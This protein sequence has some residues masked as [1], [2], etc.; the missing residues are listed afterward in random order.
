MK[1]IKIK[2]TIILAVL[3]LFNVSAFSQFWPV[4][5]QTPTTSDRLDIRIVSLTYE[6]TCDATMDSICF[7]LQMKVG[8]GY[9]G[10]RRLGAMN[11][12]IDLFLEPG[13]AI[14]VDQFYGGFVKFSPPWGLAGGMGGAFPPAPWGWENSVE[15]KASR[16]NFNLSTPDYQTIARITIPISSTT[17]PTQ[18]SYIQ[19]RVFNVDLGSYWTSPDSY[20]DYFAFTPSADRYYFG[21]CLQPEIAMAD[22]TDKCKGETVNLIDYA[23]VPDM[24]TPGDVDVTFWK[25][26]MATTPPSLGTQIVGSYTIGDDEMLFA[27]ASFDGCDSIVSFMVIT[28]SPLPPTVSSPQEFCASATVGDLNADGANVLWYGAPTGGTPLLPTI[29]LANNAVYYATQTSD[30][31][32]ESSRNPVMVLIVPETLLPS[33]VIADQTLCTDATVADIQTDGSSGIVFFNPSGTELISTDG[34]VNGTYTAIYRYGSGLNVCESTNPT[35]FTITLDNNPALAPSIADQSFCVGATIA[36][37]TVPNNQIVWYFDDNPAST[38]LTPG[39]KLVDNTYYASQGKGGS[40]AEST[41]VPVVITIGVAEPPT[42]HGPYEF[43]EGATLANI[44]L[45]GYGTMLWYDSPGSSTPLAVT[46]ELPLGTSIYY[47]EQHFGL[48]SSAR[49]AVPVTVERCN[50]LLECDSMPNRIVEERAFGDRMYTVLDASWDIS[51]DIMATL[52]SARYIVDGTVVSSGPTATLNGTIFPLGV[53][54]VMVIGF[55][56]S[57]ADTCE[58][59]VTVE[60]LCPATTS[61]AVEPHVYTVTKLAGTCW[62][63]NLRATV[64]GDNTSIAWAKLYTSSIYSD[65]AHHDSVFGRLYTWYSAVGQAEPTRSGLV[66]GPCPDGWHVPSQAEWNLLTAYD[67][68]DLKSADPLHWLT[69][70][71]DAYGFDSR[72]AGR[73]DSATGRFVDLYGFTGYWAS[74]TLPGQNSYAFMINYYCSEPEIITILG[75]DG[76]SVRCVI[77]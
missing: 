72:P 42:T 31:G 43:C 40:C 21:E 15:L 56:D 3:L 36:N 17:K 64:Y 68:H 58:F 18:D 30:D 8:S 10:A 1:S 35:T 46:T 11:L 2:K 5:E 33:P 16:S 13:V 19:F 37:I 57:Y 6:L 65:V 59:T 45:T 24:C 55:L 22:I 12:K 54:Y 69:P 4:P 60:R 70:G 51:P 29:P 50:Q 32:C 25:A 7:D 41:R 47:V 77:D 44:S 34:L 9:T 28:P 26:N 73:Y 48:C 53:S 61:T 62:T 52:D 66:Q 71:S 38:P 67:A 20:M 39:T 49:I 63:S 23:T 76:L 75:T 14:A 27:K 74:D